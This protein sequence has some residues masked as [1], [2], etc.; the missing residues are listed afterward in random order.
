[1]RT[2]RMTVG[3]IPAILWGE[4]SDGVYIHVHGKLSRKEYAEP[5]ARIAEERGLQT[6]SFDLPEHGERGGD[7]TVRCDVWNGVRD[8]NRIADYAFAHRR[9]VSL[10]ACSLGAYFALSALAD[11]KLERCLF[12]SP[13]VDMRRLV[14]DM[15]RRA[16][17]TPDRLR[18]EGEIDTPLD[19]LRW[20]WYQHILAHPVETWPIPTA[21]LYAGR[22]DLQPE[23][24]V[25]AFAERFGA[26]LT[27]AEG[28]GH[29]F[30]AP[31]DGEVVER[32]LREQ[33]RD[34]E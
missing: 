18:R 26:S 9:R 3:G 10:F 15:M 20:D 23:A 1:M 11:R 6:L 32:W 21:I 30:M 25:R 4:P 5:F 27:V 28:C 17:V 2:E 13:I 19:A 16:G 34:E 29:A 33:L 14:E 22:D 24:S 31:G 8:L 12:Q 7:R